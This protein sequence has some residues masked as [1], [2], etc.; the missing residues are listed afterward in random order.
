MANQFNPQFAH[1]H[2]PLAL[3]NR[4][5]GPY[6][7][8]PQTQRPGP[9]RYIVLQHLG[10]IRVAAHSRA[11]RLSAHEN[12]SDAHIHFAF[13]QHT[14]VAVTHNSHINCPLNTWRRRYLLT[15]S[16]AIMAQPFYD[17]P[18]RNHMLANICGGTGNHLEFHSMKALYFFLLH[19]KSRARST[20]HHI[21]EIKIRSPTDG[22]YVREALALLRQN[23]CTGLRRLH[24]SL[25]HECRESHAPQSAKQAWM[26]FRHR[27]GGPGGGHNP[28]NGTALT[29]VR[30]AW[31]LCD[32]CSRRL[33][34]VQR[35]RRGVADE[36][37]RQ[38]DWVQNVVANWTASILR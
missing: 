23:R 8:H 6:P 28:A 3:N 34:R 36:D 27:L 15:V 26:R 2:N 24:V 33:G 37:R 25:C 4:P 35:R 9:I 17:P 13:Q 18:E 19:C 29:F 38:N 12:E 30:H 5:W 22:T 16:P 14:G 20:L 1:L 7:G 32:E 10:R 11:T 31:L 21:V